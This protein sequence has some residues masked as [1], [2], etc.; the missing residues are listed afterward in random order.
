MLV[1]V[2][3]FDL[4]EEIITATMGELDRAGSGCRLVPI[5]AERIALGWAP[6]G[7]FFSSKEES[8]WHLPALS[9]LQ[10]SSR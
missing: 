2:T 4:T 10:H 1:A 9:Y 5:S 6:H 7:R 8:Q 3:T